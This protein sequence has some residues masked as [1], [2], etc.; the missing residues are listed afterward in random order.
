MPDDKTIR[1]ALFGGRFDPPHL[2]HVMAAGLV[3]AMGEVDRVLVVPC[4][5]HFFDKPLTPFRH[6]LEM[7]RQAFAIYGE[8]VQVSTLEEQLGGVSR[9][10]DTIIHLTSQHPQWSLRLLVGGDIP[11]EREKWHRFDEIER[12]APPLVVGRSGHQDEGIT[13]FKLPPV[14]SSNIRSLAA[15]GD[16]VAGFVP[17]TVARYIEKE[18]LYR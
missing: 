12:L 7:C 15:A 9:T 16:D 10:L 13:G 3:L 8:S 4:F 17:A 5:K 18:G 1:V 2:S 14:S 6:R 11:E